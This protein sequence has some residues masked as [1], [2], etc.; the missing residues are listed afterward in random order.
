MEKLFVVELYEQKRLDEINRILKAGG[1]VKMMEVDA[2][3]SLLCM[4]ITM[5]F[6]YEID[7]KK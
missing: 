3:S 6:E 1:S 7:D 4:V 5:P 2:D